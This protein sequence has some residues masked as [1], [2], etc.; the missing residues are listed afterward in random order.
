MNAAAVVWDAPARSR[1]SGPQATEVEPVVLTQGTRTA[2]RLGTRLLSMSRALI[3]GAGRFVVSD[4][5]TAE[6]Q[7]ANPWA[8]S[9]DAV[10]TAQRLSTRA[11]AE[12][13]PWH[14]YILSRFGQM[15]LEG[16]GREAYP[17]AS[18][19]GR[20]W[21]EVSSLFGPDTPTPSVVPS[22]GSGVAFVWH[23]KG[24]DLEI[25]VSPVDTTVWAHRRGDEADW[26]GPLAENR[27]RLVVLLTELA[28]R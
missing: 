7:Y 8:R 11:T 10:N 27:D 23:K 1:L 16:V 4:A 28:S 19:I 20:A 5:L 2:D 6:T 18:V 22:E 17:D 9:S 3:A 13:A 26:Y 25:E 12:A 15:L 21:T 24:W 14:D